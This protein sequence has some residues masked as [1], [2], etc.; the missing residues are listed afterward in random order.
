[1]S[2]SS[3]VSESDILECDFSLDLEIIDAFLM[4]SDL[5]HSL[6]H[7]EYALAYSSGLDYSLHIR[8]ETEYHHNTCHEGHE[9]CQKVAYCV[10][11]EVVARISVLLLYVNGS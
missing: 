8:S 5:W 2:R 4:I 9:D 1:M 10:G 7:I 6:N 3:R 11:L